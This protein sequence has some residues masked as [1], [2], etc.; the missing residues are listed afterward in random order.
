[1]GPSIRPFSAFRKL[2]KTGRPER[3]SSRR[4]AREAI[5]EENSLLSGE[6]DTNPFIGLVDS[7]RVADEA[8]LKRAFRLLAKRVHPDLAGSGEPLDAS[9]AFVALRSEYEE[10]RAYLAARDESTR[11]EGRGNEGAARHGA[12][13]SGATPSGAR[14]RGEEPRGAEARGREGPAAAIRA[15]SW[16]RRAFYE[17]LEDLLGRGF[18]KRPGAAWPGRAYDASR[19]KLLAYLAGRDQVY[20]E[21]SARDAFLAFEAGYAALARGGGG[22]LSVDNDAGRSVY[23]LLADLLSYHEL[24]FAHVRRIARSIH[25][26]AER[27]ARARGELRPLAFLALLVADLEKGPA[28]AD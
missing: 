28:I 15:A 17:C 5:L 10:A 16:D 2:P 8:A 24:G 25:P 19:E 12:A 26:D 3:S 21:D 14:P 23:F 27:L 18:P 9:R 20:P 7:G 11:G 4:P 22:W 13:S 1:M 6:A